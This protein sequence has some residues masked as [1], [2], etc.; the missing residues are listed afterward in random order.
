MLVIGP[1]WPQV[2]S[3]GGVVVSFELF[4]QELARCDIAYNVIDTDKRNYASMSVAALTVATRFVPSLISA[5]CVS[6]HLKTNDLVYM[7]PVVVALCNLFQKPVSLRKFAG[8]FD[9][10]FSRLGWFRQI[11]VRFA[12]KN[13]DQCF[14]ETQYLVEKFQPYNVATFW[15]PNP[16]PQPQITRPSKR[17]YRMRLVFVGHVRREKGIDELLAAARQLGFRYTLTIYGAVVD[18]RY[19]EMDWSRYPNVTYMGH[20]PAAGISPALAEH[21]VLV[22]PS[23]REGYPGAIIEA[24]QVGLPVVA[25]RL[26]GIQEIITDGVEGRLVEP[27][28]VSALVD[29]IRDIGESSFRRMS[30]CARDRGRAFDS[31]RVTKRFLED[32]GWAARQEEERGT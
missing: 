14:F 6:M 10:I 20:V 4:L 9:D 5:K 29:A 13:A 23:Y 27:R 2:G 16:R 32:I 7:A 28:D 24:L 3:A 22:L 1:R 12:L 25:T 21:D 8:N 26:R 30:E 15:F 11:L 17:E 18:D 31:E 19:D